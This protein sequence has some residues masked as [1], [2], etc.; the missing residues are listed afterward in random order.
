L[1]TYFVCKNMLCRFPPLNSPRSPSFLCGPLIPSWRAIASL[2]FFLEVH[3]LVGDFWCIFN[4]KV[5]TLRHKVSSFIT[6][7]FVFI[8]WY[9]DCS[10]QLA[11]NNIC[12]L[13]KIRQAI[14]TDLLIYNCNLR[15]LSDDESAMTLF[16]TQKLT[17]VTVKPLSLSDNATT[18]SACFMFSVIFTIV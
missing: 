6:T 13:S 9:S 4:T 17:N 7:D 3:M 14:K 11:Y 5:I 2:K 1:P 18:I 10:T 15:A 12:T 16:V 8:V